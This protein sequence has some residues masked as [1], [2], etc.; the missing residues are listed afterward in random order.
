M[1]MRETS[2][3][4]IVESSQQTMA[5]P[6]IAGASDNEEII[7]PCNQPA[8]ATAFEA[9]EARK[10]DLVSKALEHLNNPSTIARFRTGKACKLILRTQQMVAQH[11][12][13]AIG[14]NIDKTNAL[15]QAFNFNDY[16]PPAARVQPEQILIDLTGDSEDED[17][18][19]DAC[20]YDLLTELDRILCLQQLQAGNAL[21][22][23]L[24]VSK[25]LLS[26]QT[27]KR[28][29]NM[30]RQEKKVQCQHR[31]AKSKKE[32]AALCRAELNLARRR[33]NLDERMK[34]ELSQIQAEIG[35]G[36]NTQPTAPRLLGSRVA[37]GRQGRQ[38]AWPIGEP[39]LGHDQLPKTTSQHS[40]D[41]PRSLGI[42]QMCKAA[43]ADPDCIPSSPEQPR[44]RS[45]IHSAEGLIGY[46]FR[47]KNIIFEALLDYTSGVAK[48]GTRAIPDA[49]M[50]LAI[51]GDSILTSVL[52][53]DGYH[54]ERSRCSFTRRSP[55]E[56]PIFIHFCADNILVSITRDI[57]PIVTNKNLASV[58]KSMQLDYCIYLGEATMPRAHQPSK[59]LADLI[60]ALVGA[61]YL[62]GGLEMVKPVM[63]KMGLLEF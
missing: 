29:A 11:G 7:S 59:R 61:V 22:T 51:V 54:K 46:V 47:D 31:E 13:R 10:V 57:P 42:V 39:R 3:K 52:R 4:R 38:P 44:A 58:C 19:A 1:R 17:Q 15:V 60:E 20:E 56:C 50:H 45:Q 37:S 14:Q 36:Q 26:G 23:K 43:A 33:K 9:K 25:S 24:P 55:W 18:P 40:A 12:R 2:P 34:S 6:G 5:R 62:D 27:K 30:A 63:K 41:Q 35:G 28:L 32:K 49:N 8:G 16:R 48:I 21:S 53:E